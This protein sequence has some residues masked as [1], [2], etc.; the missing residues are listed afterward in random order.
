MRIFKKKEYFGH[1]TFAQVGEDIIMNF[2]NARWIKRPISDIRYLDI[3]CNEPIIE[4]NTYFFYNNGASGV[5]IE[6]NPIFTDKIKKFRPKDIVVNKGISFNKYIK[7]AVFYMC[8]KPGLNTFNKERAIELEK[9]GWKIRK[10]KIL[11]LITLDEVIE[12]YFEG[13]NID[14]LSIDVEGVEIEILKSIDFDS[15]R[16]TQICIEAN[17]KSFAI[18][19]TNPIIDFFVDKNYLLMANTSINYIFVDEYKVDLNVKD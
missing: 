17:N 8:D 14:I 3:G 1:R 13:A 16:P 12:L 18:K 5:V 6:P 4:N 2:I 15:T 7:E 11:P 9:N 10:E 19:E